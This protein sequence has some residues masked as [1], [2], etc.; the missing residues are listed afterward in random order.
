MRTS[1]RDTIKLLKYND[2]FMQSETRG[3]CA[4]LAG[5]AAR[6]AADAEDARLTATAPIELPFQDLHDN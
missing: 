3:V 6:F 2:I 5:F 4:L 1:R